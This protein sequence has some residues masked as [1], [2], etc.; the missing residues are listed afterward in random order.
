MIKTHILYSLKNSNKQYF[1]GVY[2]GEL[3]EEGFSIIKF[4]WSDNKENAT[5]LCTSDAW[6]LLSMCRYEW[7]NLTLEIERILELHELV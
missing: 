7:E 2:T 1:S 6:D 3:D 4:K 5:A